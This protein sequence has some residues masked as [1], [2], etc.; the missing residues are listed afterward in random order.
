LD[1][2]AAEVVRQERGQELC[3]PPYLIG[4][5][6]LLR[7]AKLE[8]QFLIPGLVPSSAITFIVGAPGALK[9]WLAYDLLVAVAQGREWLG[10]PAPRG[11]VLGL[12][13]DN[14]TNECG[15]RMLRLGLS[16]SDPAHFHSPDGPIALRLPDSAED[17]SAI[18]NVI[19]PRLLIL[20]SLRQA[21]TANENDSKEM[22]VVMG[23]LK[24]LYALG[25]AVVIV[26]HSAKGQG[27]A[28]VRGA[29][30]IEASADAVIHVQEDKAEWRKHRSWR[31]STAEETLTF[32]V[33][34]VEDRT[35]VRRVAAK[36]QR[37]RPRGEK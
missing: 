9:S 14:S 16:P 32:A 11:P 27:G 15:R 18:V 21:H 2:A 26:H 28:A 5:A 23:A 35:I 29:G 4:A 7:S 24:S 1:E 19:K 13:F 22:M 12:N 33:D 3:R 6:E 17:L 31:M 25:A 20:D 10:V 37:G 8:T 30:E 34:D 36:P